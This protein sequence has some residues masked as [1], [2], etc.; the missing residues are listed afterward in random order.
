M[1]NK[2]IPQFTLVLKIPTAQ[3]TALNPHTLIQ[4]RRNINTIRQLTTTHKTQQHDTA[5][6]RRNVQITLEIRRT[7][8]VNSQINALTRGRSLDLLRPVLRLVIEGFC[9]AKF[10]LE[11]IDFL[12]RTRR[13]IDSFRA[14]VFGELDS[15]DR[16]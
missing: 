10:F 12:L 5:I 4:Q 13:C 7:D 3:R 11:E 14:G 16:N 8:E 9:N 2:R 6:A 1:L 15:R